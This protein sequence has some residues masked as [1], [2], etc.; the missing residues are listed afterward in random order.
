[1]SLVSIFKEFFAKKRPLA[2]KLDEADLRRLTVVKLKSI[3]RE[4]GLSRY[5]GLNK[6]ELVKLLS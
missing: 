4:R 6:S 1:M 5:S 2:N 3:A